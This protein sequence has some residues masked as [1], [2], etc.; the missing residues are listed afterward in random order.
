MCLTCRS[1]RQVLIAAFRRADEVEG[2][3]M[4]QPA[5]GVEPDLAAKIP[6]FLAE[7]EILADIGLGFRIDLTL[8]KRVIFAALGVAEGVDVLVARLGIG[9]DHAL[10]HLPL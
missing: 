10:D 6:P 8:E 1:L 3:D 9:C 5:L 2:A 7:A 4:R